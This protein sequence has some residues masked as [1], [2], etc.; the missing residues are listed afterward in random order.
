MG[1]F[2]IYFSSDRGMAGN[3]AD[4]PAYTLYHSQSREVF[5]EVE[6]TQASI[7]WR[8]L[9]PFLWL[10]IFLL[11]IPLLAWLLVRTGRSDGFRRLSLLAKCLLVSLMIHAL[12]LLGFGF[13]RVG[14]AANRR[15]ADRHH[16]RSIGSR[17]HRQHLRAT[18][19]GT[20]R[21]AAEEHPGAG[22]Q[23]SG[24]H[25]NCGRGDPAA[26]EHQ[27]GRCSHR[28]F[29]R[30]GHTRRVRCPV[31]DHRGGVARR[32][33]TSAFFRRGSTSI[34]EDQLARADFRAR[35]SGDG[36]K[37]RRK[38]CAAGPPAIASSDGG[39]AGGESTSSTRR[40]QDR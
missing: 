28:S 23:A 17:N 22:I 38:C 1:G 13:W 18:A 24:V 29:P 19:F 21:F 11:T 10:L 15:H 8:S 3:G 36:R 16:Q 35:R 31:A 27:P 34:A 26:H 20:L 32:Q 6:T 7:N 33:R 9:L 30:A 40:G 4:A 39:P 5:R 14:G 12:I 25:N 37:H 2:A